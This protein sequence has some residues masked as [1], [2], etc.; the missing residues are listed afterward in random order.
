MKIL[1]LGKATSLI[2]RFL[3][4]A[5][6]NVTVMDHPLSHSDVAGFHFLVSHGYRHI[7]KADVLDYFSRG[8]AINLHISLL[9]WN[10]GADPNFWSW[11]DRTPKGVSAHCI[12]KGIDTGDLLLQRQVRFDGGQTLT[13]S[14]RK[15]QEEL[16]GLFRENWQTIRIGGVE[17][18]IQQGE[19]TYH[20]RKD[21]EAYQYLLIDGWDT[22]VSRIEAARHERG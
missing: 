9:P 21:I 8:R 22:P 1:F 14:Y 3:T 12:G 13:S 17:P 5:E 11:L 10:R 6:Q 15:L 19:G 20:R 18:R 16:V 7:L 4:E 2:H